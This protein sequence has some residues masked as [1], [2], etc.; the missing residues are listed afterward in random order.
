MP[1]VIIAATVAFVCW[2][3]NR[4]G[5]KRGYFKASSDKEEFARKSLAE[6]TEKMQWVYEDSMRPLWR[7]SKVTGETQRRYH[8]P[9]PLAVEAT[10]GPNFTEWRSVASA[11]I[12]RSGG[13][14]EAKV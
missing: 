2:Y 1:E 11:E 14:K 7:Y 12:V 9:S 6:Q 8:K 5:Y 13:K 3:L 4:E 10:Q